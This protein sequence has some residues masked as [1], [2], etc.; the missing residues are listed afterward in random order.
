MNYS[1]N[2]RTCYRFILRSLI[3]S[4]FIF[5]AVHCF[6]ATRSGCISLKQKATNQK[7]SVRQYPL[8]HSQTRLNLFSQL[9]EDAA[10]SNATFTRNDSVDFTDDLNR[11]SKSSND[12][13]ERSENESYHMGDLVKLLKGNEEH[14]GDN[15]EP[16][17]EKENDASL[18]SLIGI[19][20]LVVAGGTAITM[21]SLGIR[22]DYFIHKFMAFLDLNTFQKE[23]YYLL[24]NNF[25]FL[26]FL[27]FQKRV[28]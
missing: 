27:V 9:K 4:A 7:K 3:L 21:H 8:C 19:G 25:N 6:T 11:D 28:C 18:G 15:I 1:Y 10:T 12:V 2:S 26:L 24:L 14:G 23:H 5:C 13:S 20:G 22:Y 16:I 17:T